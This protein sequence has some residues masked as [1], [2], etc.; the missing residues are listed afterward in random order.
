VKR[1]EH[2]LGAAFALFLA[3]PFGA[4]TAMNITL[5]DAAIANVDAFEQLGSY[6]V[7]VGP[8]ANGAVPTRIVEGAVRQRVWRIN[9]A[10]RT[11]TL[12]LLAPLR[13]QLLGAGFQTLFE[14]ETVAC[15]GF[16]FRYGTQ[17]LPEPEM[18]VDLGDFRFFAAQRGQNVVSL[19]VSRSTIAGFVQM[20]E[21]GTSTSEPPRL[22]TSTMTAAAPL[23]APAQDSPAPESDLGTQLI[24]GGSVV[25][26]DLVFA[27][28]SAVLSAG[29][30][31]ALDALADWLKR[32]P[33]LTVALVGHTDAA[34]GL[35]GNIAL[36]RKRAEAVRQSLIQ[37]RGVSAAQLEAQGVGYLAPRATN[38]TDAGREKNRRVEVMVTSTQVAP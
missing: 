6:A 13:A 34:G 4:A 7:P 33:T 8:F 30:Y 36:S 23:T 21:V 10:G 3:A 16:D 24:Q 15:G 22:T 14:C 37:T 35:E 17:I 26:E 38:L 1:S 28:G 12:E 18:H 27:S 25:L 2:I 20:I 5:P 9:A 19:I 31:P 29:D 11:S 32:N